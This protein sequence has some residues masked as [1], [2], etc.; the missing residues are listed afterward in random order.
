MGQAARQ[1][2]LE[3]E[4]KV[5]GGYRLFRP[6]EEFLPAW[7]AYREKRVSWLALRTVAAAHAVLCTRCTVREGEP[8][9]FRVE[10]LAALMRVPL[11]R[12]VRALGE[13]RREGLLAFESAGVRFM[14]SVKGQGGPDSPVGG[15]EESRVP[16]EAARLVATPRRLLRA[17]ARGELTRAETAVAV[18]AVIRCVWVRK[19]RVIQPHGTLPVSFVEDVFGVDGRSVVRAKR[20]LEGR[21]FFALL[22]TPWW[23]RQRYGAKYEVSLSW[24]VGGAAVDACGESVEDA[25]R[26]VEKRPA[27]RNEMTPLGSAGGQRLSPPLGN[28][29]PSPTEKLNEH[30]K[31]GDRPAPGVHTQSSNPSPNP[32]APT[33]RD[34]RAEDLEDTKRLLELFQDYIRKGYAEGSDAERLRFVAAAERARRKA[35]RNACGFFVRLVKWRMWENISAIDEEAARERIKKFLWERPLPAEFRGL[36]A[37]KPRRE[38][39]SDDARFVLEVWRIVE[40]DGLAMSPLEAI[41]KAVKNGSWTEFRYARAENELAAAELRWDAAS[42]RIWKCPV[43]RRAGGWGDGQ[44]VS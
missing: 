21:G 12:V 27:A 11:R 26:V 2:K 36:S 37:P 9:L 20:A 14:G 4:F 22:K 13:L 6:S 10:E 35:T 39:L 25:A 30:Q 40:R 33:L 28:Q 43:T 38:E 7:N 34:V 31:P 18:A 8:A 23:H 32:T 3:V 15:W 19:G 44:R 17:V 29:K 24:C 16:P 1:E 41:L 5:D 42:A